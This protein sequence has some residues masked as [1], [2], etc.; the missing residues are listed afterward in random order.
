[1][2]RKSKF[3]CDEVASTKFGYESDGKFVVHF[4]K[5]AGKI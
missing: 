3:F 2:A 1:M 4:E 5:K